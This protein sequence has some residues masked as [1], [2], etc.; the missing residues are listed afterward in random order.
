MTTTACQRAHDNTTPNHRTQT[1][2][3]PRSQRVLRLKDM[4]KKL[5]IAR[6]TIYDWLNPKSPRYDATFPRSF[7]IGRH[8][9]GWLEHQVDEWLALRA[10]ALMDA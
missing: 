10:A 3:A 4:T 7:K 1:A 2:A 9:I 6:S 8:C 5:G